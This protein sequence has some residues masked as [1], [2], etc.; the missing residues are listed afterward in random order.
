MRTWSVQL[1]DTANVGLITTVNK[2]KQI[3]IGINTKDVVLHP[4]KVKVLKGP[5]IPEPILKA[6]ESERVGSSNNRLCPKP[7]AAHG[8]ATHAFRAC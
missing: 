7:A 8:Y 1:K 4:L 5:P 2:K 6:L 3:V